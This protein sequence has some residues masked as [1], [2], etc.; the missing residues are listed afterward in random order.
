MNKSEIKD[1]IDYMHLIGDH[2]PKG[3]SSLND[4]LTLAL[5]DL[6]ALY[7]FGMQLSGSDKAQAF[8]KSIPKFENFDS[9]EFSS[10]LIHD[11]EHL[12]YLS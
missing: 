5:L 10:W 2:V 9:D 3:L 1:L 11:R 4:A 7:R 8:G 12:K 6:T